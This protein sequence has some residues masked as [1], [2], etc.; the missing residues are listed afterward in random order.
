MEQTNALNLYQNNTKIRTLLIA[1]SLFSLYGFIIFSPTAI[2]VME[3]AELFFYK[4][5]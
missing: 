3:R 2:H 5:Q 4:M 1:I